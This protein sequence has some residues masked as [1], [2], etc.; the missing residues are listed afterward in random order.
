VNT[1]GE[2][3]ITNL[4]TVGPRLGF[5]WDRFLGFVT[6]GAASANLKAT[7]CS[8]VTGLCGPPGTIQNGQTWNWGWY[9]GAGFEYMIHKG[10]LVDVILGAEYQHWEVDS[11]RAFCL[12]PG[13][14]IANGADYHL[15]A[16][17]DLVRARL[18]IKTQGW[19]FWG[20]GP[21]LN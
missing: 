6:G 20:P 1:A 3:K 2:H 19:R 14:N 9:A 17:G 4:F 13:C 10:A 18:T 11:E 15:A 12:N 7:Y 16:S 8:T 21:A 5:A